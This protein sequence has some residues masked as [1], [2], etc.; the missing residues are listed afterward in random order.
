[1][2]PA[3]IPAEKVDP[4]PLGQPLLFGFANRAAPNR[5]LKASMTERIASWNPHNLEARGIPSKNLIN[6]YKRW[7]EGALGTI[8][9][10]NIMMEFDQLEAPGNMIIPR[11]APF[12]GERF[13]AF[14][15]LAAQSKKHGSLI[16]G[17]V[18]H[19]GRQSEERIQP[20]PVSASDVQLKGNVL[21]MT[22]ARPHAATE[23]EL[24]RVIEGFTHAAEYLH[25]AGFD[26]IELHGAHGYLLAQFL[27]PSTNKRTDKYGGD[28]H[29]RSRIILEIAKSIRDKLPASTGFILG[30]KLN[31]VEFQEG[32][33][34]SEECRELCTALENEGQ[35]DFVELSGGTY[36]SLAFAH[37]K[38]S[39]RKREAFFLEFAEQIVQGL[40]R[41][42]KVF[43]TGGFRTTKGMVN[44]LKAVDGVGLARPV[45]QEFHFCK[46]ILEGKISSAIEQALDQND[47]GLT[48]IAA[49]TQMRQVGKDQEPIDLSKKENVEA[50]QKDMATWG[51]GMQQDSKLMNKYGYV[52]ITSIEARPYGV[53]EA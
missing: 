2:S 22:Y 25:K 52:D 20:H 41:K 4:S 16:I 26:G 12:S 38:D 28:L 23:E 33:F 10:G 35:F 11:T 47:F 18:S 27:S 3:R 21:G 19:P 17:Q 8:M 32:G 13:E 5:F 48:N 9:T 6:V 44:A 37:K 30:I 46:D 53:V 29:N 1:M 49:G 39:T 7:G 24:S 14:K 43:V 34:T 42:T 31:S 36:Q 50:F 15:E 45:C 51:E 40:Q